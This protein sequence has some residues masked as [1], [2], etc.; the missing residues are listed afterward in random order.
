MPPEYIIGIIAIITIFIIVIYVLSSKSTTPNPVKVINQKSKPKPKPKP[1]P[2]D[3]RINMKI[4]PDDTGSIEITIIPG[5]V[6]DK[7][8]KNLNLN[9]TK[10]KN[11]CA[12]NI[13]G[14]LVK[15]QFIEVA[16]NLISF[17]T[18][19]DTTDTPFTAILDTTTI[20]NG[21][22]NIIKG[23]HFDPSKVLAHSGTLN[24]KNVDTIVF[25]D[26]SNNKLEFNQYI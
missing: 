16:N 3:V 12:P 11:S 20:T 9:F 22:T 5:F 25:Y 19:I 15:L 14:L 10:G 24:S 4:N 21:K 13:N 1:I 26:N 18:N 7:N 6:G 2:A 23:T 17:T 8:V